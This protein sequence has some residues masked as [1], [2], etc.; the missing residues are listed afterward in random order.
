MDP[1]TGNQVYPRLVKLTTL[2]FDEELNP[3]LIFTAA[4]DG[5]QVPA[6]V[7]DD[8]LGTV[9]HLDGGYARI[10]NPVN[11]VTVQNAVSLTFWAKQ[12]AEDNDGAL[13]S[14]QNEDGTQTLYLTADGNLS[15]QGD[16]TYVNDA[17]TP[18]LPDGE[19]KYVGVIL[20]NTGYTVSINGDKVID[21]TIPDGTSLANMVSFAA[22]APYIYV[23]TGAPQR[24][25]EWWVDDFSVY[26]NTITAAEMAIPTKGGEV[27]QPTVTVGNTDFSSPFFGPKSDLMKSSGNT[28]FHW[29]FK[30]YTKG[31]NNWENWVLVYTNGK[32]FG[33]DGYAEHVVLR[34]D[35]YGWGTYYANGTMTS[36]YNWDTFTADMNG[37]T[38]DITVRRL[39]GAVTMT[40]V[41]TTSTGLSYTYT[42]NVDGI[43]TGEFG[44]FLT[45]EAAYLEIDTQNTYQ[46]VAYPRGSNIF[47]N[48][49]NS[50]GWWSTHSPLQTFD[51]NGAINFQFYNYGSGGGN[52]NNWVLVVTNG[53]A[54]GTDGVAEH[55]VMRSDAYGWGTYYGTGVMVHDFNWD[56]F[57]ADMQGAYVD[58]T[59][60]RIGTRFDM[61]VK[62]TTTA[63]KV[64][65]YTWYNTEFAAGTLG[66]CFTTDSSH[67]EFTSIS[68]YPLIKGK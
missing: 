60:K 35:A 10:T 47:G 56:T 63:G 29:T 51:D 13:F 54:I 66:F 8:S 19:W 27:F 58:L 53:I 64:Y 7:A 2:N 37:A 46:G 4:H 65:N 44:A 28:I 22:T 11:A 41:T 42:F 17:N 59:V 36:N 20:S 9:L 12:A 48:E 45:L 67:I 32:A 68:T 3:E 24:K 61:I 39:G 38:V 31:A 33:E 25:G 15:W 49:D 30:N 18:F 1:P 40:A 14:F 52:W 57:I 16:S 21:V 62:V 5:G 43:P 34:A 6:I 50:S 55:L 23:G 26:R